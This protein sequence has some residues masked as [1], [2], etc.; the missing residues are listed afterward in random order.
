MKRS[1]ILLALMSTASVLAVWSAPVYSQSSEDDDTMV[2]EEIT[3]T[4]RRREESLREVP[5]T[6]TA[7]T[8]TML[9]NASEPSNTLNR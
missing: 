1:I 8:A 5:G 7:L 2:I 3:V 4:A 6:V 9:E